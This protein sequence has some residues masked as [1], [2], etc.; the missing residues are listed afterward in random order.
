MTTLEKVEGI[1]PKYAKQLRE[2]GVPT[3]KALLDMVPLE[4]GEMRLQRDPVSLG[5]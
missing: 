5:N 4:K 3:T 2:I 1:G